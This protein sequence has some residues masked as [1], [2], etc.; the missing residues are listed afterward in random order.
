[1]PEI[2]VIIPVYNRPELLQEAAGSVLLQTF[3]DYELIIAD[4]GSDDETA[5]T[6][7]RIAASGA[8]RGR[9]R[10]LHLPHSGFPGAVRNR[11]AEAAAGRYLAFQDS[12]DKWMP[13]KL[14][15]QHALM[16]GAKSGGGVTDTEEPPGISHTRELWLRGEKTVSQKGQKHRRQGDIFEDALKKCIIGPSTVMIE[17]SLYFE[18]GGFHERIEIAEDY[19]YWLRISSQ[20]QV[21]YLDEALTVKRAGGWPQLSEK[22]GK[23][24]WFRLCA[25][26]GLLEVKIPG[27]PT[28]K[29][30]LDGYIWPGFSDY[31]TAAAA[32]ELALKCRLWADGSRKR[33]RNAEAEAFELL[34]DEIKFRFPE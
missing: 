31:R 16:T 29:A 30:Y 13:A 14:E 19:E 11:G 2:S 10:V 22:Y 28:E 15:K 8:A 9:C 6:A 32:R 3:K 4:D 25:L 20:H 17:R 18:T 21:G 33:G 5:E 27:F 24:E 34:L 26:A 12:D 1:M 7:E 23:I